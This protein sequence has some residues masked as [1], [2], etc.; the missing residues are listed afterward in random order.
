MSDINSE[1]LEKNNEI[2]FHPK[3]KVLYFR[4]ENGQL[5]NLSNDNKELLTLKKEIIKN[6]KLTLATKIDISK[7][8]KK[9]LPINYLSEEISFVQRMSDT[10]GKCYYG[11]VNLNSDIFKSG[12]Y[13]E[14][15]LYSISI[16]ISFEN[17][18]K[19]NQIF[20][21]LRSNRI[22][23]NSFFQMIADDNLPKN[24]FHHFHIN[25]KKRIYLEFGFLSK[26]RFKIRN[27][28]IC[29]SIKSLK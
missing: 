23:V 5:V 3:K 9:L 21:F 27:D 11:Q 20:F 14:P 22:I 4:D 7:K 25:V 10:L 29:I 1:S 12:F 28:D 18:S 8:I 13:L 19:A 2:F 17:L 24:G 15:N 26:H 16:T 6:T